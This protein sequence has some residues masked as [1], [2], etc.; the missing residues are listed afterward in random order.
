VAREVRQEDVLK[1][2]LYPGPSVR[3]AALFSECG[4]LRSAH[5]TLG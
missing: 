3:R 4:A 5:R 2:K 1:G